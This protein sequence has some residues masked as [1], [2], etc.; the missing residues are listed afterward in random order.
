M[1]M[2]FLYR[3][4][5]KLYMQTYFT[6]SITTIHGRHLAFEWD[7][8]GLPITDGQGRKT[9]F[10]YDPLGRVTK[11]RRDADLTASMD[12]LERLT[13]DALARSNARMRAIGPASQPKMR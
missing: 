8:K 3:K 9:A 7:A 4:F 2:F 6:N 11:Y 5:R 12:R 13:Q 10:V 1:R